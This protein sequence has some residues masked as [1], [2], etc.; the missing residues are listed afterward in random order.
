MLIVISNIFADTKLST[1][2]TQD[3]LLD[4]RAQ[5]K[6]NQIAQE[7]KKKLN[8]NIYLDIKETNG[9]KSSLSMK[10]KIVQMRYLENKIINKLKKPYVVL[11]ISVDQ[12][13]ANILMSEKMKTIIDK[14]DILDGYV[15]P[16]LA[17][18]DKNTL[19]AKASAACLN[20]FAQIA[21]SIAQ[22]KNIKLISSIGS[23]GKT[24][25]TIWKVFMYSLVVTGILLYIV[26]IMR[27]K[28]FKKLNEENQ[29]D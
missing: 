4:P 5:I 11:M 15:I 18:K 20:G 29:N 16:L 7:V 12:M 25:G 2:L 14:N 8:V 24:A 21:D 26:I 1:I 23:E 6:I 27:E 10:E 28:K 19:F 17:S 3:G 13:Y 9:I 22:S